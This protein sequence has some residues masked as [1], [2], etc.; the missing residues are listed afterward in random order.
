M[1]R[2]HYITDLSGFQMR[3]ADYFEWPTEI[4]LKSAQSAGIRTR[5]RSIYNT[6][7]CSTMNDFVSIICVN[8]FCTNITHL[9]NC[10]FWLQYIRSKKICLHNIVSKWSTVYNLW[11]DS[12]TGFNLYMK[13]GIFCLKLDG[14]S[15]C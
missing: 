12:P 3:S 11:K 14:Y 2:N 9:N 15:E 5:T 8:N 13:S 7:F 6:A 10:S 1:C 4:I